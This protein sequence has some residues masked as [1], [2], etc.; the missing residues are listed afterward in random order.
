MLRQRAESVRRKS[1]L[2]I[3]VSISGGNASAKDA[4][5]EVGDIVMMAL[6]RR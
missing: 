3:K 6:M 4:Q 1:I 5:H 2:R